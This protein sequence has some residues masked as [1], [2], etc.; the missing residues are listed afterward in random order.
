MR[1]LFCIMVKII[2]EGV[3]MTILIN[4]F[5]AILAMIFGFK[6]REKKFSFF[7]AGIVFVIFV[8]ILLLSSIPVMSNFETSSLLMW[9]G[10]ILLI[11]GIVFLV[12]SRITKQNKQLNLQDIAIAFLT[13]ALC[14]LVLLRDQN[15]SLIAI[16]I[17]GFSLIIGLGLMI[18][19]KRN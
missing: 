12:I 2:K 18:K 6:R 5:I 11:L 14:V 7:S 10:M 9:L 8:S 4:L 1:R 17:P 13:A 16:V 15:N 3:M 19:S